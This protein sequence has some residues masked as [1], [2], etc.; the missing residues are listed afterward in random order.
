MGF[1]REVF[2]LTIQEYANS[3]HISYNAARKMV[4][5]Y[6]DQLNIGREGRTQQLDSDAVAFL[7]QRRSVSPDPAAQKILQLQN[8]VNEL[9]A[10]VQRLQNRSLIERI[11]NR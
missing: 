9:E 10:E 7:D 2:I 3:R 1:I 11:L 4:Q 6:R 8:R 5:R